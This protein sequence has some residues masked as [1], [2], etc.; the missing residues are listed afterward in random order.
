MTE[1]VELL[2]VWGFEVLALETRDDILISIPN[3]IIANTKMINESAPVSLSRIRI[4]V[5]VASLLRSE[6]GGKASA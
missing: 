4:K 2:P 3:S 5:G 6:K 1:N